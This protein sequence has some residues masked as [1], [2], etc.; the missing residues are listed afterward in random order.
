M[1]DKCRVCGNPKINYYYS[2]WNLKY[3]SLRCQTKGIRYLHL[4]IGVILLIL[5]FFIQL[6]GNYDKLFF[7]ALIFL[8]VAFLGFVIPIKPYTTEEEILSSSDHLTP[9]PNTFCAYHPNI[10]AF[11]QCQKCDKMICSQDKKLSNFSPYKK[12][13]S[14]GSHSYIYCPICNYDVF[15][16]QKLVKPLSFFLFISSVILFLFLLV[17]IQVNFFNNQNNNNN[18]SVPFLLFI[19]SIILIVGVIASSIAYFKMIK[20]INKEII[21]ETQ[22]ALDEKN[23]FLSSLPEPIKE[24]SDSAKCFFCGFPL[25][26]NDTICPNCGEKLPKE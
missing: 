19:F 3:C 5:P 12:A 22:K 24:S 4:V 9:I 8:L 25:N 10:N 16:K 2:I 14:T 26:I 23:Q 18:S 6:N 11:A 13:S 21:T 15:H 1:T 20:P 7:L 17:F